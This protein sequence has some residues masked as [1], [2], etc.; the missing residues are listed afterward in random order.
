MLL[1]YILYHQRAKAS[2]GRFSGNLI[3]EEIALRT[4][5]SV[6][7]SIV[8]VTWLIIVLVQNQPP[9]SRLTQLSIT[10]LLFVSYF[11][12]LK[13]KKQTNT[14]FYIHLCSYWVCVYHI[15]M[16]FFVQYYLNKVTVK[17]INNGLFKST[18]N[19]WLFSIQ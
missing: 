19:L 17:K 6:T 7:H 4:I 8:Y 1:L 10:L 11:K 9:S 16:F 2:I 14:A 13:D 3:R 15:N 18:Q 12:I 5:N